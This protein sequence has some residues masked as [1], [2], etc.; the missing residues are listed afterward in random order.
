MTKDWAAIKA[1]NDA[2]DSLAAQAVKMNE[3]PNGPLR[4]QCK[5]IEDQIKKLKNSG[6]FDV[7]IKTSD[8]PKTAESWQLWKVILAWTVAL[9][10]GFLML[11]II[12]ALISIRLS[13]PELKREGALREQKEALRE[14]EQQI[15]EQAMAA[16][17]LRNRNAFDAYTYCKNNL[18][19]NGVKYPY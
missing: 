2:Y 11:L 14:Q 6:T 12:W 1:L 3:G 18:I 10:V 16:C 7:T 8:L 17:E 13:A 5:H 4:L 9:P 19:A 15:W